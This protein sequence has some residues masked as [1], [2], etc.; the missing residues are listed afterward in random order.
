MAIVNGYIVHKEYYKQKQAKPMSHVVYMKT[1]HL[2]LC[3]LQSTDMYEGNR[4]G[5]QT[6]VTPER[7]ERLVP[8]VGSGSTHVVQQLQRFRNQD[9]QNKRYRAACKVCSALKEGKRA[10]TSTYYCS[11]CRNDG[12]IFLC[13]RPHRKVRGVAVT[14][15]DIWHRDWKNGC[16]IHRSWLDAF[17][18][19]NH[20]DHLRRRE[21]LVNGLQH[22]S[23]SDGLAACPTKSSRLHNAA[24]YCSMLRAQ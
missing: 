5:V 24:G 17:A 11:E 2:Q 3:Q 15:W 19:A 22:L 8:A 23:K 1:L 4:F 13:L 21:Q 16:L 6:S 12:P 18:I 20:S 9:T 10:K 7:L 14:C